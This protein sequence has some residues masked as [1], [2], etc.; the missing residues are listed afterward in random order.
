MDPLT[1][2]G[3]Y[4]FT[5]RVQWDDRGSFNEWF[6]E[7]LLEQTGS[8]FRLAQ[9]N[10]ST[11]AKGVLRG[12]HFADVPPGQAKYVTCV[13][14]AILDVVVDLRAGSPSFG[15]HEAV[16]LDSDNRSCVYIAEG[17]GHGFMALTDET[18]VL[19]LCSE[20]YTP[21]REH[22]V[23][24][25]DVDLGIQWPVNVPPVLSAKDAAAPSLAEVQ[26]AGLLPDYQ[27]CLD[28]HAQ[29]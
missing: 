27:V 23:H 29:R 6:R 5:P 15:R 25:L 14:G 28:Y 22:G 26:K 7:D 1:I 13:R 11:S 2:E 18:M 24:P 19:Y 10:C 9:A 3:A 20:P 4:Q 12:M 8:S 16:T 17:L 21:H